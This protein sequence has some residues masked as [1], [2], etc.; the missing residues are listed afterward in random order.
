MTPQPRRE[1]TSCTEV[2]LIHWRIAA[3]CGAG[4]AFT[5]FY[6]G[7]FTIACTAQMLMPGGRDAMA[8]A[9]R[10]LRV[11]GAFRDIQELVRPSEAPALFEN[12]ALMMM[13]MPDD[14]DRLLS[15]LASGNYPAGPRG[16]S[17][18]SPSRSAGLLC[19]G[20]ALAAGAIAAHRLAD[21]A[22]IRQLAA[23][24]FLAAGLLVLWA[25]AKRA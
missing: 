10:D 17:G 19:I 8:E 22:A 6:R 23:G 18:T 21:H 2:V 12:F 3:Q 4:G 16:Q 20:L 1:V 24:I 7:F 13:R 14:I 9:L 15:A 11:M 25:A 5:S